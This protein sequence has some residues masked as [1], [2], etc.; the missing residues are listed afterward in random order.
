MSWR[1]PLPMPLTSATCWLAAHALVCSLP[2]RLS[3]RWHARDRLGALGSQSPL[4]DTGYPLLVVLVT[5]GGIA[6]SGCLIDIENCPVVCYDIVEEGARLEDLVE[7][8][9]NE[10][11]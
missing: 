1:C 9:V 6:L 3:L 8:G 2:L 5:L 10:R 11:Y 7:V 4:P